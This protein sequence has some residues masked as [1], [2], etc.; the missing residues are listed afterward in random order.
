MHYNYSMKKSLLILCSFVLLQCSKEE[1]APPAEPIQQYTITVSSTT[2]GAV[3]TTG[4]TYN[5]G[6]VVTV[7]A[8]PEEGYRFTG[9]T[10]SS[11][12]S[13]TI[14]LTLSQNQSLVANFERIFALETSIQGNWIIDSSSNSG[15]TS[16]SIFNLTFTNTGQFTIVYSGGI[17]TGNYTVTSETA[18]SLGT[19]GAITGIAI[20]DGIITFTITVVQCVASAEGERNE[21]YEEGGC[22]NF[23]ECY[24]G[25]YAKEYNSC[26]KDHFKLTNDINNK[27]FE[28]IANIC[29]YDKN[30]C[31]NY[32]SNLNVI[33]DATSGDFLSQG[34]L[35]FRTNYE[36]YE[37][38]Y[39]Y[40]IYSAQVYNTS[41]ST[42]FI[43]Y[44]LFK[45]TDDRI[46]WQS[47][48]LEGIYA[49]IELDESSPYYYTLYDPEET[50]IFDNIDALEN[51]D[52]C[53]F[54]DYNGD[55]GCGN[56]WVSFENKV[57]YGD[58]T[59]GESVLFPNGEIFYVAA[60]YP[61]LSSAWATH[62][63]A[64]GVPSEGAIRVVLVKDPTKT[65][66]NYNHE[67]SPERYYLHYR[68]EDQRFLYAIDPKVESVPQDDTV[69]YYQLPTTNG[70]IG[71]RM[72]DLWASFL[73]Y[74]TDN[75]GATQNSTFLQTYNNTTWFNATT[76]H[77][78]VFK[79]DP[80]NFLKKVT[81]DGPVVCF[82]YSFGQLNYF[83]EGAFIPATI[84]ETAADAKNISFS[85]TYN[86]NGVNTVKTIAYTLLPNN[87]V[88]E[89]LGLPNSEAYEENIYTISNFDTLTICE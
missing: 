31:S 57:A 56:F 36:I 25:T 64:W 88:R 5:A 84:V 52:S 75:E 8:T 20:V 74:L 83:V 49:T 60:E 38:G 87:T 23:L 68:Y 51:C 69:W 37:L 67:E 3:S 47:S 32:Y 79:N 19:V 28:G 1:S 17:E 27:W 21:D 82:T 39:D 16:C 63:S 71:E 50:T 76:G 61:I 29:N 30:A 24:A 2:G 54:P 10:G 46:I 13:P 53:Y 45:G 85:I 43:R 58:V 33:A 35:Q 65:G 80:L 81:E 6:A 77:Y 12:T 18:I 26:A 55:I 72:S 86:L 15:K 70:V 42:P 78:L 11:E 4:G 66:A 9:W 40:I 34:S 7:T 59:I 48:N 44:E 73:A 89:R 14:T 22:T 62:V 41:D